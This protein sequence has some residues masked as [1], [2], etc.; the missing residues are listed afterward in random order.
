MVTADQ[1][2]RRVWPGP[3]NRSDMVLQEGVGATL[4]RRH[5]GTA[6]VTTSVGLAQRLSDWSRHQN[7]LEGLLEHRWLPAP[8]TPPSC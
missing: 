2:V 3:R 8:H 5:S 4:C 6:V 7:R 1:Q